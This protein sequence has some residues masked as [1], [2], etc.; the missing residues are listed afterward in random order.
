LGESGG[1]KIRIGKGPMMEYKD[2]SGAVG[3]G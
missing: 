1:L 2:C 3:N